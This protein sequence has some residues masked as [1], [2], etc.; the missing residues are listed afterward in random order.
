MRHIRNFCIIAHI[1]HGKS[2]LADRFLEIT[3]TIAKEK[4]SEQYLD[5][6]SLERER[7]ITIKMH[8]VQMRYQDYIL[9]LIDTPGHVD[10]TYEV[11]R[12]LLA[13]EGAILLVDVTQGIQAQ[14]ISNF[15][16]AKQQGLAIIPVI[17]KIDLNTDNLEQCLKEVKELVGSSQNDIILVSAKKGINVESLFKRLIEEIPAP[18]GD[19][20]KPLKAL[21]FDS[22]YDSFKGVIAYVRI[23]DGEIKAGDKILFMA[24]NKTAEVLEVGV[25]KP[26]LTKSEKLSAGEIGWL[27]TGVKEPAIVR[28]GDTITKNLKNQEKPQPLHG[29]KEPK[30][31]VFAG[32]YP[33]SAEDY[34]MFRNALEKLKL[35]DAA[36]FYQPENLEALGKGFRLGF[37]G[38]LHLEIT[39]ERLIREYGLKIITTQPTVPYQVYL[40]KNPLQPMEV[41]N[42]S[43]YPSPDQILETR[44]P[45]AD[46]EIIFPAK[47]LSNLIQLLNLY[48]ARQINLKNLSS[49]KLA[50]IYHL[51]FS[52]ILKDLYDKIKSVSEGY[53]S[54]EYQITGFEPT[55]I[56]K[57]E[58]WLANKNFESLTRLVPKERAE[59][60]A[61]KLAKNLK[62][63]LPRQNYPVAIQIKAFSRI[64]ARETVNA[65]YKDVAGYL[66]GGDR[67]RKEK[68]WK[69][70]KK[71]K[72]RILAHADLKLS[73]DIFL[74]ILKTHL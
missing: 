68:L 25:F 69:K 40:K 51:P 6:M 46:L 39:Y 42:P 29:Y 15:E 71:G 18:Q 1:D 17:N 4:L 33:D 22:K 63:I 24:Q 72:R 50:L 48:R 26:E 8:P 59:S 49:D 28:V 64:I 54:M 65:Y 41:V 74:K 30:S 62:E 38:I 27:A 67:T 56:E 44:E 2:T 53:A 57:L 60:E 31:M 55:Q 34:E 45:Y 70:Q 73:S 43:D 19:K 52:E 7:G 37:L 12:S 36:L 32:F 9:N 14:T 23:F 35:N 21:I 66:Y 13:V 61:R 5:R 58:V 10:F 20:V 3:H 11:S 16:L 47:Y